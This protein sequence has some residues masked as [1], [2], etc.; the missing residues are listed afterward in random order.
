[1]KGRL[2]LV[3]LT[4]G[5]TAE[6]DLGIALR[7]RLRIVGT[8]LRGR[9]IKEKADAVK[10]FADDVLPLFKS[11][12]LTPNLYRTFALEDVVDAYKHLE[13]NKSFGKIVLEF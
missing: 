5:A 7:K 2:I 4:S 13:S 10:K 12:K 9:S 8:M 11:R 1:M 6:F 3:G